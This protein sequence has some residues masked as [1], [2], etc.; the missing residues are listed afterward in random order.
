VPLIGG[1]YNI[2]YQCT[3]CHIGQI[4]I[5]A[6]A[7][8]IALKCENV[9]FTP[10]SDNLASDIVAT[11]LSCAEAE[12]LVRKVG[13]PLGPINGLP[14]AE[15]DGFVCVRTSQ[16]EGRGLPS[17]TYECTSGGKTVTFHRT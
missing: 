9:G 12:A 6:P 14:R 10:N 11:G 8:T 15:A 16:T 13:P 3:A 1:T 2:S 17:S 7:S 4:E 5:T